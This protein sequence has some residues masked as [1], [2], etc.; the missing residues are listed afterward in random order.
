MSNAMAPLHSLYFYSL[1]AYQWWLDDMY[2][3][4][5]IALPINSNPGWVFPKAEFTSEADQCAYLAR[6]A[7][8]L[9]DF[10]Q[11]VEKYVFQM[12]H[13]KCGR[14]GRKNLI[15]QT[16]FPVARLIKRS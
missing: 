12:F 5:P 3:N 8:G 11:K 14:L 4:N 9:L 6:L 7:K 15:D 10:K 13:Y 2:M 1:Q 16:L